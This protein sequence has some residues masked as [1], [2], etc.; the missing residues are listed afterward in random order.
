METS[1]T[2]LNT[3]KSNNEN[4][5]QKPDIVLLKL[6]SPFIKNEWVKPTCL[7]TEPFKP[8]STCYASGWGQ[9]THM[10]GFTDVI[11]KAVDLKV[12]DP[13]EC[14]KNFSEYDI[15]GFDSADESTIREMILLYNKYYD[16]CVESGEKATCFGDS[17]GPL[18]CEGNFVLL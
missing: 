12:L 13:K 8:D 2:I 10:R 16:I 17:G 7:P 3:I 1:K 9:Q 15:P 5:I 18:I 14:E 4:V 11:L 6:E